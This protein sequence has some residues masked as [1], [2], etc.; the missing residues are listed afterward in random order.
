MD[1]EAPVKRKRGRPKGAITLGGPTWLQRFEESLPGGRADILEK[2]SAIPTS[3][4]EIQKVQAA[5]QEQP[6][7]RPLS[8]IVKS[9][10]IKAALV[11]AAYMEGLAVIQKS[12]AKIE[13]Q[14]ALPTLTK[15]LLSHAIDGQKPCPKCKG[16]KMDPDNPKVGCP[17]CDGKGRVKEVS[18][19]KKWAAEYTLKIGGLLEDKPVAQV[20]VNQQVAVVNGS[21]MER[22]TKLGYK[23]L[24]GEE[25][26]DAEGKEVPP[27]G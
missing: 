26:I 22:L 16:G 6:R 3:S 20:N 18:E 14:K 11:S 27:E 19:N 15:D 1:E 13:V 17:T 5:L 21:V 10:G 12:A 7:D 25:I 23:A 24:R 2:L 9:L 8:A 4:V